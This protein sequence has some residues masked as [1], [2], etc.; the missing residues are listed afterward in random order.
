MP[1]RP[2]HA[3]AVSQVPVA[4]TV[5]VS[6]AAIRWSKCAMTTTGCSLDLGGGMPTSVGARGA[7]ARPAA[8]PDHG[9]DG[10]A[11]ADRAHRSSL[12]GAK[13]MMAQVQWPWPNMSGAGQHRSPRRG[14]VVD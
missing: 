8:H 1:C 14:D 5:A 12:S 13:L 11:G 2:S 9:G 4:R 3:S 7:R 6:S 10:M